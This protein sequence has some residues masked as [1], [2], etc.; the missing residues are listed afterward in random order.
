MKTLMTA[1]AVTALAITGLT[2]SAL[3]TPPAFAENAHSRAKGSDAYAYVPRHHHAS[4]VR[5]H[6]Y[7]VYVNGEYRG[8][9]PDPAI[10]HDLRRTLPAKDFGD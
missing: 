5:H 8:S 7:S 1:I 9:D 6:S 2:L 3:T 4:R 10:R